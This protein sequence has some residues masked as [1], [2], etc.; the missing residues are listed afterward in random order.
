ML[1]WLRLQV[2]CNC[3]PGQL[4]KAIILMFSFTYIFFQSGGR[5]KKAT[6]V[7][8]RDSVLTWLLKVKAENVLSY[9]NGNFKKYSS[10]Q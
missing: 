5:A 9:N 1:G 6:H 2:S 8:Y 10:L 7:P 4:D 3:I